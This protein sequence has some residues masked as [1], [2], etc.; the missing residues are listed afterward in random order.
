MNRC[1]LMLKKTDFMESCWSSWIEAPRADSLHSPGVQNLSLCCT[2]RIHRQQGLGPLPHYVGV[3]VAR[4][5][6]F[7]RSSG[8]LAAL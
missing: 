1:S 7:A 8:V 2:D 3:T 4:S 5:P 6:N